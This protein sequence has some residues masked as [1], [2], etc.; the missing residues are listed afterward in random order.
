M[1]LFINSVVLIAPQYTIAFA[2]QSRAALKVTTSALTGANDKS[3]KL[4]IIPK[5]ASNIK[6]FL[7]MYV[8]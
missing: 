8:L 1:Y 7:L 3:V 2:S 6:A 5:L 4:D